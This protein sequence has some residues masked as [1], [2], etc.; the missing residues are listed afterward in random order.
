MLGRFLRAGT[1]QYLSLRYTCIP[2]LA[3][4]GDPHEQSYLHN[5]PLPYRWWLLPDEGF[6]PNR[7]EL[8]D[9]CSLACGGLRSYLG[10]S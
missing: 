10:P 1:L 2:D 4:V 6:L 8:P 7:C 3:M 9:I 5:L